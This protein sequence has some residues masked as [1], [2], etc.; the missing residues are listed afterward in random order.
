MEMSY[1][2]LK[3]LLTTSKFTV[4]FWKRFA[5]EHTVDGKSCQHYARG[6]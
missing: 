6:I 4:I 3:R 1:R 2:L 5:N